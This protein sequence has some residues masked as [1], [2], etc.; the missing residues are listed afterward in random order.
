[1]HLIWWKIYAILSVIMNMRTNSYLKYAKRIVV[2]CIVITIALCILALFAKFL[3]VIGPRAFILGFFL[4]L[5]GA[6]CY[7]V[8]LLIETENLKKS[9]KRIFWD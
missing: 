3:T 1:M 4:I 9:L 8:G 2:G 5:V 6:F 7:C